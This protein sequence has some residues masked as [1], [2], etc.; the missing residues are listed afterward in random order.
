MQTTN[1]P[2]KE[3]VSYSK[4]TQTEESGN[5][6]IP[7]RG[8]RCSHHSSWAYI[9]QNNV[10]V[11]RKGREKWLLVK[12][13]KTKDTEGSN[14]KK[15]REKDCLIWQG[16]TASFLARNSNHFRPTPSV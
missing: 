9:M 4:N 15:E 3:N 12:I 5:D 6:A 2:P 1:I 8:G 11:E 7:A 16:K 10:V 14:E 13:L